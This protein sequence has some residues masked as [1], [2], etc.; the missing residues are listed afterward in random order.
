MH[1]IS[2]PRPSR[3]TRS[4]AAELTATATATAAQEVKNAMVIVMVDFH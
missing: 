4:T 3:I 2:T 1:H